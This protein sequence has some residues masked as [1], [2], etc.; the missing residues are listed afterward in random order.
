[1]MKTMHFYISDKEFHRIPSYDKQTKLVSQFWKMEKFFLLRFSLFFSNCFYSTFI[2]VVLCLIVMN[3]IFGRRNEMRKNQFISIH[4]ETLLTPS[5]TTIQHWFLSM[6]EILNEFWWMNDIH[7][8]IIMKTIQKMSPLIKL[9]I[10][11]IWKRERESYKHLTKVDWH[12]VFSVSFFCCCL[13]LRNK[14][15]HI[16]QRV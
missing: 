3:L 15:S 14:E 11:F 8:N 4:F 6:F 12:N 1:M 16:E 10:T 5:S 9:Y 13:L 2:I 7:S